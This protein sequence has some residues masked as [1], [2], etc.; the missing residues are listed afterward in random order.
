MLIAASTAISAQNITK[1]SFGKGIK[2]MAEDSSFSLRFGAR[3]QTLFTA[4]SLANSSTID[5]KFFIRRSRLKFDGFVFSPKIK[6][7]ME[8][9]L[10]NRDISGSHATT[11]N[12]DRI[13][14][15]AVIKW[16]FYENFELWAGQTKLPGNRERVISSSKLQFVDRSLLNSRFNID[17][18]AGVQ[19]RHHFTIGSLLVREAISISNGE[20]RGFTADNIGGYDYTGRVEFLPFGKFTSKG[21][22]FGS[23]LKREEKPKLSIGLTY[24]F[25]E[26]AT[27]QRGQL[28]NYFVS[29]FAQRDLSTLFADLMF[30]YNGVSIMAEYANKNATNPV[31]YLDD[32]STIQEGSFYTGIGTS[33]QMGYLFKNNVE[34][35]GR[36]TNVIPET[37]TG[38]NEVSQYTIGASKYVVGHSL[39][40]QTDF[41]Y[42]T[43]GISSDRLM[44]RLQ[45][46]MHL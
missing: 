23:D 19:L 35:A 33:V 32:L 43:E 2:V 11:S 17:R 37:A 46:E 41:T 1:D 14:L 42:I 22:Y 13:I 5:T 20:G 45:F 36:Y 30:K 9:G 15:D 7:K 18:D 38:R 34:I 10:S 31:V 26:G 12:S 8:F 3:F 24:D 6:Y 40:V 4:E 44:F 16:N 39:K 28:G 21:D 29:D 25:N 27:R